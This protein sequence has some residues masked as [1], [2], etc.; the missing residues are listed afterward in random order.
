[1]PPVQR[2]STAHVNYH[3]SVFAGNWNSAKN[4][5]SWHASGGLSALLNRVSWICLTLPEFASHPASSA[6]LSYRTNVFIRQMGAGRA[7]SLLG[8]GML[9]CICELDGW[10]TD[11]AMCYIENAW[12]MSV[13]EQLTVFKR[14]H[15]GISNHC[16][17]PRTLFFSVTKYPWRILIPAL[18]WSLILHQREIPQNFK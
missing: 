9:W 10:R 8:V 4:A 7:T 17:L 2:C 11:R 6:H 14:I 3:P 1:M 12:Q 13:A 16:V 18:L 5:L 15:H